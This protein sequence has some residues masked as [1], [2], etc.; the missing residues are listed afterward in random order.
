MLPWGQ[1]PATINMAIGFVGV[2]VFGFV[3][4]IFV[5]MLYNAHYAMRNAQCTMRNAQCTMRNA[6]CTIRNAQ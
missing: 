3:N 2:A 1:T 4:I 6:Q 5:N